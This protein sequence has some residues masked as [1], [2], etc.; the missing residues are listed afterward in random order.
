MIFP[1]YTKNCPQGAYQ[2]ETEVLKEQSD[3]FGRMRIGDL[4]RQ[5]Q[6]ITE[7]HF[8]QDAGLSI[9]ELT[10][11]GKSWIISWTDILIN[12]LPKTGEKILM[13]IWP[14]KNKAMMYS[15]KYAFYTMSGEPLLTT[16]SLFLLMDQNT[17]AVAEPSGQMKTLQPIEIAGEPKHPKMR[18]SFP[19]EYK[20]KAVRVVVPGEIDYNGHLNN[21]HYLDWAEELLDDS[22]MEKQEPKEIWVQYTKELRV[23]QQALLQ[24]T[25]EEDTM[26][27]R[28]SNGE[29]ES[30]LLRLTF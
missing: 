4:A 2:L 26:Y 21:S 18:L 6:M 10:A 5:M 19:A 17:R 29:N 3:R 11:Q 27:L 23:G 20:N 24:F 13:R 25:W 22:Y 15:R 14:G 7:K 16:A 12:R 1:E 8:D 9:D 28:G 30:F